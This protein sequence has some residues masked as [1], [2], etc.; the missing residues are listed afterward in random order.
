MTGRE[1]LSPGGLMDKA[2]RDVRSAR[3]LL[4][5]D[6]SDGAAN[7]A[8]YAMFHAATS[9]LAVHGEACATH[10]GV[11]ARFSARFVQSGTFPKEL[12]RAFNLAGALEPFGG[13]LIVVQ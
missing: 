8:Y 10:A 12:G 7:R 1:P 4:N 9:A 5:D 13:A 6:D 11:I 3:M 2:R